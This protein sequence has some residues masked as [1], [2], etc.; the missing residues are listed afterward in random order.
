MSRPAPPLRFLALLL[1]GWAAARAAFL[2]PEWLYSEPPREPGPVIVDWARAGQLP[3]P[4]RGSPERPPK[5]GSAV[6]TASDPARRELAEGPPPAVPVKLAALSAELTRPAIALAPERSSALPSWRPSPAAPAGH[7]PP[8]PALTAAPGLNRW[9]VSGWALLRRG[10]GRQLAPGGLLGGSQAGARLT[11]QLRE[12]LSLSARAYAPV[13]DPAGAEAALGIEWQP[14]SRLPV[15]LLAERRQ[16]IG[17]DGRST[18]AISAHGGVS[19]AGLV[20]PVRLDAYAQAGLVGLRSRDPFV[21]GVVRA[22]VPIDDSITVALGAWGAAQPGAA[23]LD[24]GPEATVRL[25]V[26]RFSLSAGYRVR[27]AG[28]ARPGSGPTLTLSTDF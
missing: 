26:A 7:S 28:E 19:Q 2:A 9:S 4:E 18:F 5:P 23:R 8:I 11:Y 3:S 27:V 12:G 10:S 6:A 21:D 1:G 15:R 17:R 14:A 13:D 16:A 22:G 24:L 25:P 20:G